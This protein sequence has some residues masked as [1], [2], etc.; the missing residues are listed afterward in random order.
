MKGVALTEGLCRHGGLVS[1]VA[2][3]GGLIEWRG[4]LVA[5]LRRKTKGGVFNEGWSVFQH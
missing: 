3:G 5:L 2:K 1:E 4:V